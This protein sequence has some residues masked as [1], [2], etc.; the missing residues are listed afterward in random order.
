MRSPIVAVCVAAAL[1]AGCGSGSSSADRDRPAGTPAAAA[2][3]QIH[4]DEPVDGQALRGRDT[5]GGGLAL[6]ARVRGRAR[7]HSTVALGASCLPGPCSAR[8]RAGADGR[9]SARLELRT[10][11][12]G[13]FVTIDAGSQEGV[14]AEGSAVV[15][16]ELVSAVRA[17][18]AIRRDAARARRSARRTARPQAPASGTREPAR[19][20]LPRD[21]LVIGDSLAIGMADALRAALPGWQVRVDAKISRPLAEGLRILGAQSGAPAILAFSLFTNDDPRS[22]R[23]LESAVRATASRPGG[24][25]VWATI[26]APPVRGVDYG[27]ANG[28]LRGLA[29]DPELALSLKIVDWGAAVAE[30]PA[31]IAGDGVHGTPEGYRVRGELY[32]DAMEACAGG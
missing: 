32:A 27:A 24:C 5:S 21:V 14:V 25:A 17:R 30:R 2:G 6:R 9:W 3:G 22:I 31:L 7:P 19:P 20:A 10:P 28:L 16:V 18:R 13:R 4:I 29:G 1:A 11:A 12:A 8:A 23:A 26:A 15:T